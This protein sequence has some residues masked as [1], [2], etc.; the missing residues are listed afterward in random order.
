MHDRGCGTAIRLDLFGSIERQF[1]LP[2]S[3]VIQDR[4]DAVRMYGLL[5]D[6]LCSGLEYSHDSCH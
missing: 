3:V 6:S 4:G 2:I 1:E 5:G